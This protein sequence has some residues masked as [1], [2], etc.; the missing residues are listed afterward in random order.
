MAV[1]KTTKMYIHVNARQNCIGRNLYNT[2]VFHHFTNSSQED[3]PAEP[4][5]PGHPANKRQ[6]NVIDWQTGPEVSFWVADGWIDGVCHDTDFFLTGENRMERVWTL[7]GVGEAES[8]AD[9]PGIYMA[10]HN[11]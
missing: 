1:E 7:L 10:I 5:S 11:R 6:E 8:E 3:V 4:T 2:S 9:P